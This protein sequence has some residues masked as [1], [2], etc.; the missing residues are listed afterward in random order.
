MANLDLLTSLECSQAASQGW[1]LHHVYDLKT[2]R[3]LVMILG[4][5]S[6]DDT[7][8]RVVQQAR[9]GDPLAQKALSL[10]MRSNKGNK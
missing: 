10:V 1:S 2:A 9:A 5:P 3:W 7:C 4:S 6:V 8:A